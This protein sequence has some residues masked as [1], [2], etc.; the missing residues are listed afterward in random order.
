MAFYTLSSHHIANT[1]L[2]SPVV[3]GKSSTCLRFIPPFPHTIF[4]V[5]AENSTLDNPPLSLLG[6]VTQ[7]CLY[8]LYHS[9]YY[10]VS[11]AY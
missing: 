5:E 4:W 1:W 9:N 11:L 2:P 7:N 8:F 6:Q 3:S 10:T